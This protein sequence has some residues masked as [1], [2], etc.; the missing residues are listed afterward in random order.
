MF[1]IWGRYGQYFRRPVSLQHGKDPFACLP[2]FTGAISNTFC[3]VSFIWLLIIHAFR[4]NAYRHNGRAGLDKVSLNSSGRVGRGLFSRVSN[5]LDGCNG[6]PG[7]GS[8]PPVKRSL[9]IRCS[10]TL[11][12]TQT[13]NPT[14]LDL[15]PFTPGCRV[16][17]IH[18]QREGCSTL[19][20]SRPRR[21]EKEPYRDVDE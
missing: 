4:S 2:P 9:P 8:W 21:F 1:H 5:C 13:Q 16:Q 10:L 18:S 6:A 3:S 11:P 14:N 12:G 17:L 19:Y 15:H 7:M 20:Q